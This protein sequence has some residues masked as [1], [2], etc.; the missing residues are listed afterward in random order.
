MNK[1]G[2]ME[3]DEFIKLMKEQHP[4]KYSN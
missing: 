1:Y 2:S 3:K 4:E